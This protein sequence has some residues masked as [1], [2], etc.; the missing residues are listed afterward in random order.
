MLAVVA[1]ALL[2]ISAIAAS[3][4]VTPSSGSRDDTFTITGVGLAPGLAVDVSFRSPTGEVF[5]DS[6]RGKVV[7]ADGDG[8]FSL[9]V[10]P[11][12]DF[13]GQSAGSWL[14]QACV[15]GTDD[16]AQ[17]NFDVVP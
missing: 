7:V 13:V 9:D 1:L 15:S 5:S 6:G 16:C 2:P 17:A 11:S 4:T 14:I 12:S 10:V 3:L 8:D